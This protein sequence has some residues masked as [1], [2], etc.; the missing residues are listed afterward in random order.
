MKLKFLGTGT[1]TGV[2]Q[3]RCNCRVCRS[4]DQRDRRTRCSAL[5]E[6]EGQNILI[7]CGPDF[8][9]Q[10]LNYH[11]FGGLD[12]VILTHS[13]YDH[14]GGVDDLRP[15][16]GGNGIPVYCRRDVIKDLKE[17]VPYCFREHPYPG[18]PSYELHEVLPFV[19]FNIGSVVIEPLEIMHASLPILGYKI[20][21][22]FSYI[23]DSK[24]I[25]SETINAISGVDTLVINALRFEEHHSHL[26]LRQALEVIR[27]VSPRIAY[28][29]HMSHQIGLHAETSR[30]LPD[31]VKLAYD[32]LT[33]EI[34]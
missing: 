25:P 20:G 12:A 19:M 18:V 2:P 5:I 3:L 26:N 10:M 30:L 17:R 21:D 32:G 24:Y 11:R 8:Y 23:T 29:T 15:Y 13:H 22:N 34:P 7:D 16:C 28:L 31:N 4:T 33:I 6:T 27:A 1:S 14:V 9:S